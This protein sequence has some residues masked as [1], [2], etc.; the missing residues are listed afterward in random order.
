M[1]KITIILAA[2]AALVSCESLKEEFQPV[3]TGKYDNPSANQP[4][5]LSVT[6]SIAELASRY[7]IGR[8]WVIDEN[9]VISELGDRI[10]LNLDLFWSSKGCNL[11]GLG[12]FSCLRG[13]LSHL[14]EYLANY[15]LYL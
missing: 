2:L 9:I 5:Q 6:H 10:F 14:T 8:P 7:Q 15:A 11:G 3:F 12:N 13:A 1:K 4:T